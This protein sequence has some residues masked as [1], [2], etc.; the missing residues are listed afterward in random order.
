MSKQDN[1]TLTRPQIYLTAD[2][3][4]SSGENRGR[5]SNRSRSRSPF[6]RRNNANSSSPHRKANVTSAP[7]NL[8]PISSS[9]ASSEGIPSPEL[10]PINP[11]SPVIATQTLDLPTI[12][13]RAK[14]RSSQSSSPVQAPTQATVG[15]MS[16]GDMGTGIAK[17]LIAH[18]YRVFTNLQGRR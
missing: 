6:D 18:N 3:N 8:S 1:R 4:M 10:S 16:M 5:G 17:M 13:P 2:E 9:G 7:R 14:D 15:I 12:E 11:A